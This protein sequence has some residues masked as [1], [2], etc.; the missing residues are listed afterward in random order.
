MCGEGRRKVHGGRLFQKRRVIT[1]TFSEKK[2]SIWQKFVT[3]VNMRDFAF[4]RFD[5]KEWIEDIC[6]LRLQIEDYRDGL[7][8]VF[9]EKPASELKPEHI[10]PLACLIEEFAKK[11]IRVTLDRTNPIGQALWEKYR[12]RQYWAGQQDYAESDDDRVLNLQRILDSE[13]EIYGRRVSEYLKTR[14]FHHKDMTPVNN[15][16]T[17]ALYNIFDHA[18]AHGN[19][20]LIVR[21]DE[22]K[23]ELHVAICDFG[24]GIARTV[25][26]FTKKE[27]SD[28]DA[29]KLAM[30]DHFTIGSSSHNGGLGLGNIRSSC[31]DK[32]ILWI[33][34]NKAI[35]AANSESERFIELGTDFVGTLVFYSMSLSH[36]EDEEVLEDF[37]W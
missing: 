5:R 17:E 34:S 15:S 26:D 37:N 20:F 22:T 14:Y 18:D 28:G 31:T 36:F 4:T 21:F 11:G 9:G 8:L 2:A 29:I 23:S 19:A 13:K 32:D 16:I 7:N 25:K 33:V 35:L 30:K 27:M 1:A 24:K 6:N 10:A 3:F 12:L